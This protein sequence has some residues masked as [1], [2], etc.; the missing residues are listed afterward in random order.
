MV[1]ATIAAQAIT[2]QKWM[3]LLRCVNHH[4]AESATLLLRTKPSLPMKLSQKLVSLSVFRFAG[5][6]WRPRLRR[7]CRVHL[8]EVMLIVFRILRLPRRFSMIRT[9]L[10]LGMILDSK[11]FECL[12]PYMK[13]LVIVTAATGMRQGCI[14]IR[15]HRTRMRGSPFARRC[16]RRYLHVVRVVVHFGSTLNESGAHSGIPCSESRFVLIKYHDAAGVRRPEAPAEPYSTQNE[17]IRRVS[18]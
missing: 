14:V 13:S 10:I 9:I 15:F 2:I 16:R 4:A 11:S 6:L 12:L 5:R 17:P 7:R 1:H 3:I 18:P 8:M